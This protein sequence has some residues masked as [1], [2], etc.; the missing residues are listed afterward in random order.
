MKTYL[1][2]L[3]AFAFL[4][5]SHIATAQVDLQAEINALLQRVAVLQ[6]QIGSSSGGS[7][8]ATG[9]CPSLSR[10]LKK[11]MSGT[12]VS[13]LQSF[14]TSQ[15]NIYP[16]GT[17]SG[18]FGALTEAA[19]QR[20]QVHHGIVYTG[21]AESTGYGSVG[22]ATRSVI[23]RLCSLQSG[24]PSSPIVPPNPS[25]TGCTVGGVAV[26]HG[27]T[28]KMYSSSVVPLGA[29]CDAYSKTRTC[30]N[31]LLIGDPSYQYTGCGAGAPVGTPGGSCIIDSTVIPHGAS[32]MFYRQ[33]NLPY[34]FQCQGE[35]RT[36]QNGIMS[37]P[38][39]YPFATCSAPTEPGSC[40]LD[41]VTISHGSSK[42]FY[43]QGSA[44]LGQQCSVFG[45]TRTCTNGVLS[46]EDV[47]RF[48]K[49]EQAVAKTC[50]VDVSTTEKTVVNHLQQKAFYSVQSV[51]WNQSCEAYRLR[52]SV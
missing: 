21:N 7:V 22:P 51:A 29:S 15:S 52:I 19:V 9:A 26:P 13:A 40:T 12:D 1:I 36:C 6:S 33:K 39:D 37:A 20:F 30:F 41:G 49:C 18:Y 32:K 25:F 14:L 44:L 31:G 35:Y 16:E 28:I 47:F 38:S 43:K 42:T 8:V 10:V 45:A 23:T 34:G 50:S 2:A 3:V 48:A 11:G 46:G 5:M 24:T 17:V 27:R 4:F